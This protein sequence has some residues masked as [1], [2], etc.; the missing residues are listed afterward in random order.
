MSASLKR[1]SAGVLGLALALLMAGSASAQDAKKQVVNFTPS[2]PQCTGS[3]GGVIS[4]VPVTNAVG[5][6]CSVNQGTDISLASSIALQ[7]NA[8]AANPD[9]LNGCN[10]TFVVR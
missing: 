6:T 4:W 3:Q 10:F 2:P 1:L 8:T 7:S 5:F 9:V